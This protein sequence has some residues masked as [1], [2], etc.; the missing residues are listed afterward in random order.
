[1][2]LLMGD[3]NNKSNGI[4]A[5]GYQEVPGKFGRNGVSMKMVKAV[6]PELLKQLTPPY[7]R[8]EGGE[9]AERLDFSRN[10]SIAIS[11]KETNQSTAASIQGTEQNRAEE[12]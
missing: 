4:T 12:T 7:N 5:V 6:S 11:A 9:N 1:M 8:P 2:L 3:F 10:C